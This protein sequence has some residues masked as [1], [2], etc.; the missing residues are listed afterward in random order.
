MKDNVIYDELRDVDAPADVEKGDAVVVQDVLG[1]YHNDADSGDEVVVVYRCRQVEAAK[2]TGTSEDISAGDRLYRIPSDNEVTPNRPAGTAG[3]DYQF[4]GW[5]KEDAGAN[6]STVLM[7]FDGT[8][9]D[10]VV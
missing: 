6:E 1:F 2:S 7:N 4:C 8:R 10:E 9:Y 3:T 5:A